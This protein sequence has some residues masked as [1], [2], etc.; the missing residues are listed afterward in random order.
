MVSFRGKV[1]AGVIRSAVYLG[2]GQQL[3][4]ESL[5][6]RVAALRSPASALSC[7]C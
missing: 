1:A 5:E 3:L 6:K 2:R 4:P 7:A